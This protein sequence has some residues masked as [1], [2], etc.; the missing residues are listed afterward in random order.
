MSDKCDGRPIARGPVVCVEE[1][2]HCGSLSLHIGPVSLRL[3]PHAFR[4]LTATLEEAAKRLD[5]RNASTP[6]AT[7]PG[8]SA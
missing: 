7:A 3:E 1:C 5:A 2:T 8:G 6:T 4:L